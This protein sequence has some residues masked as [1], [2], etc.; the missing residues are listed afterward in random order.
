MLP[1]G[2]GAWSPRALCSALVEVTLSSLQALGSRRPLLVQARLSAPSAAAAA[3][4]GSRGAAAGASSALDISAASDVDAASAISPTPPDATPVRAPPAASGADGD[5]GR[6]YQRLVDGALRVYESE[7]LALLSSLHTLGLVDPRLLAGAGAAASAA[8]CAAS[9]SF[10]GARAGPNAAERAL[11][12][13]A[14]Y[15]AGDATTMTTRGNGAM[16]QRAASCVT[17][18]LSAASALDIS[19]ETLRL[20][21]GNLMQ[22][23]DT[24]AP[25]VMTAAAAALGVFISNVTHDPAPVVSNIFASQ[26][27]AVAVAVARSPL[28]FLSVSRVFGVCSAR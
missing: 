19:R 23:L 28:L 17:V 11:P 3:A 14:H 18:A 12:L 26:L 24:G 9:R 6:A 22:L 5:A 2:F 25:A 4:G 7:T 8:S 1:G 20:L 10:A 13:L 15:L 27:Q 21:Q 16:Q